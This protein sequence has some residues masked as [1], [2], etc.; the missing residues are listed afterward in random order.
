ME[1]VKKG[2]RQAIMI[3]VLMTLCISALVWTFSGNIIDLFGISAQAAIYCNQ[4]LKVIALIN[5]I[6]S[7]YIPLFGVFQ[8]AG[9]GGA[10]TVV[11]TSALGTRVFVTYLFRYSALFGYTIIWWNGLFGFGIGCMI[12]WSYYLSGKWQKNAAIEVAANH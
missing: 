12:T 7:I 8:G 3:S 6:L 2:A 4:H 5:I 9:H 11:A 1:R 10:P